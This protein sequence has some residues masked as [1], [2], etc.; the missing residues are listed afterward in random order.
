MELYYS[1]LV[2]MFGLLF[3][4]LFN[5]VGY[6]IPNGM[7]IVKPGSFCPKC[8]H[9]LKWY[10]LILVFSF[11]FQGGKCRKCKCKISWF[12]PIVE[13]LTGVLFLISYLIFGFSPEFVFAI[14]T[15]SFLVIVIV[16][17]FNYLVIS[18]EVTIFFSLISV[19]LNFA[20]LGVESGISCII[21]GFFM[22]FLMYLIMI[23]GS[24]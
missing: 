2:F 21:Y 17:D 3:G 6:R 10:E 22:F 1:T 23:M 5:V 4:S 24:K 19:I 16:S 7:S 20:L 9:E 12:Y 14:L 8:R 18:D 15:A 13:S 11:I